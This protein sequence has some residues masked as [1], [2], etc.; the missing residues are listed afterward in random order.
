[1]SDWMDD[2]ASRAAS[3]IE[4]SKQ[5]VEA[6]NNKQRLIKARASVVWN[7]A[8]GSLSVA[9]EKINKGFPKIRQ[10]QPAPTPEN[11]EV[12]LT[13]LLAIPIE[14]TM[15]WRPMEQRVNMSVVSRRGSPRVYEF[16]VEDGDVVLMGNGSTLKGGD[17][18]ARE[19]VEMLT[20]L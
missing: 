16:D 1:M 4:K 2:A 8:L 6:F 12:R 18:L 17:D 5:D 19:F 20:A 3:G 10:N 15:V 7:E 14:G 13:Y 11:I 9:L